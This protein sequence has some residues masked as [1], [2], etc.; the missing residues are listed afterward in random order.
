MSVAIAKGG[1]EELELLD[2][3]DQTRVGS[4][5]VYLWLE[6]LEVLLADHVG[7]VSTGD[8]HTGRVLDLCSTT[9]MGVVKAAEV[10][11]G[12]VQ[13]DISVD[14]VAVVVADFVETKDAIVVPH[15]AGVTDCS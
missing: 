8:V 15:H 1:A 12:G 6:V 4:V 11:A 7:V 13:V 3:A 9:L 5:W 10:A 2:D 14:G